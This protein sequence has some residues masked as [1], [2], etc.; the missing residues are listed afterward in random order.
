MKR[1][2]AI[3]FTLIAVPAFAA[4]A[5]TG[6]EL[7]GLLGTDRTITLTRPATATSGEVSFKSD[8]TASGTI[9]SEGGKV[10]QVSGVWYIAGNQF[11][12]TWKG[13]KAGTE[14]CETWLKDGPN[15]ARV[16]VKGKEVGV[17]SW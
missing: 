4:E 10:E 1:I 16:L 17:N 9:K 6:D 8:G 5:M 11:C 15:K 13:L 3:A 12:Y 7:E 2:I 14:V